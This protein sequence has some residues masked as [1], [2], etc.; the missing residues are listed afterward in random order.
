[1]SAAFSGPY[2]MG[3]FKQATAGYSAG[4]VAVAVILLAGGA[5]VLSST[6]SRGGAC[7]HASRIADGGPI[8]RQP[9]MNLLDVPRGQRAAATET[10]TKVL[11]GEALFKVS[12]L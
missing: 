1:M 11:P 6:R 12:S 10:S 4:L 3:W 7:R 8:S 5:L 9:G 2:L